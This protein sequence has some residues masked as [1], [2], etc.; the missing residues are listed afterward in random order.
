METKVTTVV[1]HVVC[2]VATETDTTGTEVVFSRVVEIALVV[3]RG[4]NLRITF[5]RQ[6]CLI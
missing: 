2:I 3:I 5:H 4:L 1:I 6:V